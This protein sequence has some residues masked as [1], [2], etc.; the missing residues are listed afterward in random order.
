MEN[1]LVPKTADH[2]A[3]EASTATTVS[4]TVAARLYISISTG[5]FSKI[6]VG[7]FFRKRLLEGLGGH[8]LIL[9]TRMI[10]QHNAPRVH[11]GNGGVK[12]ALDSFAKSFKAVSN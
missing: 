6:P 2:S 10:K 5:S 12:S 9:Q 7:K 8:I 3:D 11:L 1:R 4:T